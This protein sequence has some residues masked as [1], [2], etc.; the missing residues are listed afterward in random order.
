MPFCVTLVCLPEG[1]ASAVLLR[2]GRVI[3]GERLARARR[4]A[5]GPDG[6]NLARGPARLCQALGIDREQNGADVRDPASPL[7]VRWPAG[8]REPARPW[9][10]GVGR[11]R[12]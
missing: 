12:P 6:R 9:A 8:N 4:A 11:A 3:E 2:A 1:T 5:P 10:G 7:P